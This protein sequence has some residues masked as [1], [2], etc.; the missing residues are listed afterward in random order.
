MKRRILLVDDD[1]ATRSLDSLLTRSGYEV[2]SASSGA[3]AV[4]RFRELNGAD[5]VLLDLFMPKRDGGGIISEL[6]AHSPGIPVVAISGADGDGPDT[7]EDAKA[8]GAVETIN[9]PF[10]TRALLALIARML[11][12]A[13]A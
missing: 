10:G 13:A 5:L 6:R 11:A 9:K 7:L 2:I 3:E 1:P 12:N 4:Q 8:M